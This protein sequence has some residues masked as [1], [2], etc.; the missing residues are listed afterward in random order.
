MCEIKD[1]QSQ[2]PTQKMY[3]QVNAKTLTLQLCSS[4]ADAVT[5]YILNLKQIKQIRNDNKLKGDF[6]GQ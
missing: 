1:C 6:C 5:N 2:E 4:H 3:L